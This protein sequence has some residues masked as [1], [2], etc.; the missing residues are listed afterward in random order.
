MRFQARGTVSVQDREMVLRTLEMCRRDI[1]SE[2]VRCGDQ[3]TLHGL[4]PSPRAVNYHDT[5]VLSV[6]AEDDKTVINADVSFQASAFLGDASQDAV[7]RS[8]LDQVF[9]QMKSQIE[10]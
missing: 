6:S 4:G 8:K 2:V 9:D 1:S 10:L 7:V 3:I 5:T